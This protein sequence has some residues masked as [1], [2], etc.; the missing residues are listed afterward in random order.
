M[1]E[2]QTVV[3]DEWAPDR[4]ALAA[5]ARSHL[6][7]CKG[8]APRVDGYAPVAGLVDQ[9][10][11]AIAGRALGHGVIRDSANETYNFVG[12]AAKLELVGSTPTDV[13]RMSGAYGG[14]E[15]TRWEFAVLGKDIIAVQREDVPQFFDVEAPSSEFDDLSAPQAAHVARIQDQIFLGDL[16]DGSTEKPRGI[17]WSALRNGQSYPTPG[18]DAALAALAGEVELLGEGRLQRIIGGTEVGLIFCERDI[19]RAEFIGAEP[20]WAFRPVDTDRGLLTPGA[21]VAKGRLVLYLDEDGWFLHDYT[22]SIHV[23]KGKV[24]RYF[25]LDVD[26]SKLHRISAVAD[27]EK[28]MFVIGYQSSSSS[29]GRP[30]KFL[31]YDWALNRWSH[32]DLD[33]ELIC[34]SL[35]TEGN[36][37][38]IE[39]SFD[40]PPYADASVDDAVATGP[41]KLSAWTSANTLSTFSGGGMEAVFETGDMGLFGERVGM[42]TGVRPHAKGSGI[43]PTVQVSGIRKLGANHTFGPVS[44]LNESDYCPVRKKARYHRIR[45]TVPAGGVDVEVTGLAWKTGDFGGGSR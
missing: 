6:Y 17:R 11:G 1:G 4:P 32:G 12:T 13:T 25:F 23:G 43:A 18:S 14:G 27:P 34:R 41:S 16:L 35:A 39:T 33:H 7:V 5:A 24:D 29:T 42:L 31:I 36:I 2:W 28:T 37:D 30:D 10:F 40:D 21:C 44:T 9:G 19:Y 22:K 15:T 3:F 20:F 8:V 26:P 45:M 38:A